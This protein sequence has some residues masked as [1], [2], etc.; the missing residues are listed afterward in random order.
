MVKS[1]VALIGDLNARIKRLEDNIGSVSDR[2]AQFA[3][4][5][6]EVGFTDNTTIYTRAVNGSFLFGSGKF[7]VTAVGDKRSV[8][9]QVYP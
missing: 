6:E 1:L 5:T 7:G 3:S 2:F 9:V 8:K 4:Y